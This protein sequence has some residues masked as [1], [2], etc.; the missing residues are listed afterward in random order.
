VLSTQTYTYFKTKGGFF[1][2]SQEDLSPERL[3]KYHQSKR[4]SRILVK[5]LEENK[6]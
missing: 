5:R 1:E 2:G 6:N 3:E 4:R